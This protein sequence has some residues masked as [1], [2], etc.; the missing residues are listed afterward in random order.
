[1]ANAPVAT[2]D[3]RTPE[4]GDREQ[5]ALFRLAARTHIAA[6]PTEVYAVVSDLA[7]SGE[8]SPECVGGTWISGEPGTVGAVFRG[9]NLRAADVVAWAP[10]VRGTW[11]TESEVVAAEPGR[12]FRWSMRDTAGVRQDSV[13]SYEIEPAP[14]GSVLTHRFRMG[15]ATEGI[16]G[17]TA[18]LD[19]AGKRRFLADWNAKVAADL[20]VTLERI[21]RVVEKK[22]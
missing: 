7:R 15:R 14:G 13:W 19:D 2:G 21:K 16:R 11:F 12:S 17:I 20:P 1:M 6:T 18:A 10:V 8:W 22:A 9:E 3:T 5:P 4:A